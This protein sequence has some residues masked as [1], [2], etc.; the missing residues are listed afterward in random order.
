MWHPNREFGHETKPLNAIQS[1][2][3]Q[4]IPSYVGVYGNE[5]ADELAGRG[6]DLSNPSPTVLSPS[7][8]I[9]LQRTKRNLT[10]RNPPAHDWYETKNPGLSLQCR[11]SRAHQ[12]VLARFRSGHL[13]SRTLEHGRKVFFTC[14]CFTVHLLNCWGIFL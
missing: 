3:V 7:E 9:S 12:T 5:E 10:W 1:S 2:S 13:R 4:W 14:P 6:C 11:S 8:I